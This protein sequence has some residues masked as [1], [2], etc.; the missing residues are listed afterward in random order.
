MIAT[1]INLTNPQLSNPETAFK[2]ITI[3]FGALLVGQVIFLAVIFLIHSQGFEVNL[4]SL[5]VFQYVGVAATLIG[6]AVSNILYRTLLKAAFA[7]L[8]STVKIV[9][10][11]AATLARLA[12]LEAAN[13][14]NLVFY[15][16]TGYNL[17]LGTFALGIAAFILARP[18]RDT[19]LSDLQSSQTTPIG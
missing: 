4:Q 14:I 12:L 3:V 11:N 10:Y 5:E 17:F 7:E 9:R 18:Q 2:V 13:L 1:S 19:F 8:D 6:V 15:L 16:I